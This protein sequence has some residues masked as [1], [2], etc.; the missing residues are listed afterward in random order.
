MSVRI[1]PDHERAARTLLRD[2]SR[3]RVLVAM[4]PQQP[5]A[6]VGAVI[7]VA[8]ESEIELELI[9]ADLTGAF[10]FL[11]ASGVEAV[12][13]GELRITSIAGAIPRLLSDYVDHVPTSLWDVDRSIASG[14]FAIDIVLARVAAGS[15]NEDVSLGSMIGYMPS[16]LSTSASVGFEVVESGPRG[17]HAPFDIPIDRATALVR[18][19]N[20]TTESETAK[21]APSPEHR[22]IGNQVATLIPDGATIQFGLGAVPTAVIGALHDKRDLGVHS[23]I[24]AAPLLELMDSGVI[25]GAEKSRD[26]GIHVATGVLA[27]N[28]PASRW[29]A[30]LRLAPV[31]ETHSP[32]TLLGHDR[33]WAVNS[34]FEIDLTGQVNAEYAGAFRIASG[35][36]QTDFMRAAHVSEG[37]GAILAITSRTKHGESRI[38]QFTEP[39]VRVTLS[40]NDVDFVVTE[41]GVAQ[42][43]DRSAD[44]RRSALI[45]VAHPRDR[46]NL[47]HGKGRIP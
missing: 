43:R 24:M 16:A 13:K 8:A 31:S 23:G 30:S 2:R 36:G 5:D 18:A 34:A 7:A 4:S 46:P 44:E 41:F 11:D 40:G 21:R 26:R 28:L 32:T 1:S 29:G 37:G 14:A 47:A 15:T 20:P 45:S 3:A 38:R 27:A 12:I 22:R 6:L 17:A 33:L 39:H 35:G 42:L 9:V 10:G 19:E 25:S